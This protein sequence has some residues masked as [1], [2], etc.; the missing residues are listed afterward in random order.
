MTPARL[1]ALGL[2]LVC[3]PRAGAA[4]RMSELRVEAG[5]AS[6]SQRGFDAERAALLAV[7]WRRPAERWTFLTSSNL[8][9]AADSLAAAQGVAVVDLPWNFSERFRT[10]IGTAGASFSLRSAG[11]GGNGNVFA[12]QHFVGPERGAFVGIA[13]GRTTRD[14]VT[15]GSRSADAGV[16]QRF[17]ML[18]LSGAL[19]HFTSADWPLLFASGAFTT[20]DD[21]RFRLL[22]KM[23]TVQV[24][25]GPHDFTLNFIARDGLGATVARNRTLTASGTLQITER[26]ALLGSGGR[27]LADPLRGLPQ[28]DLVTFSGRVSFGPKPLPV[29]QRSV[30]AEAGV[31]AVAGGGGELVVRVLAVESMLVEVAGDFSNWEPLEMERE[32]A[33]WVARA[34]VSTGKHRVAV[35]VNLGPWRAP[36]NLARVRDDYGGEAGLV[37]VP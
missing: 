13:T 29:M 21:D 19:T 37:V 25:N 17:G 15:S 18:Y 12:R 5:A 16:W 11:R 32:G 26:F 27:Q 9:Y 24:R 22:D 8:T 23:L 36:R 3:A 33:F 2:L 1:V 20:P 35:R 30:I 31:I 34:R 6:V 4:Q 14:G 7:L 28:A 10:E